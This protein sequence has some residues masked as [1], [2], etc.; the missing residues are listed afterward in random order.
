MTETSSDKA[1]EPGPTLDCHY[2][3]IVWVVAA[4]DATPMGGPQ[5][6]GAP[7]LNPAGNSIWAIVIAGE[8]TNGC[9]AASLQDRRVSWTVIAP[10]RRQAP[11]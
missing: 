11:T 5:A 2:R 7:A 3:F 9:W 10:W 6:L 8:S 4:S 1:Q